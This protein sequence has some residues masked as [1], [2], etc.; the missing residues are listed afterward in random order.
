MNQKFRFFLHIEGTDVNNVASSTHR[1]VEQEDANF[2]DELEKFRV[3]KN[4]AE[5]RLV[6]SSNLGKVDDTTQSKIEESEDE[7]AKK[8]TTAKKAKKTVKKT[9]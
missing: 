1:I 2:D 9:K 3:E 8:K 7:M 4:L 6:H 5:V